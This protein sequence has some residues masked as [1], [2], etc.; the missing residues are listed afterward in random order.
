MFI[1]KKMITPFLLPPGIVIVILVA[2]GLLLLRKSWRAG[3]VNIVIGF[4]LWSASISPVSDALMRGLEADLAVPENPRGDVIILLGGGVYDSVPDLSGE[5]APSEDTLA[6]IVTAVR[7]QTM[8]RVPI[9]VCGGTV[10]PGRKAEAPV[11]ARI[12]K[13]LGVPAERIIIEDKSRDT[14]ENARYANEIC[15]KYHFER[16]L[17]VTSAYHTRRAVLSFKDVGMDVTAVPSGF[18]T[19]KRK[20]SWYDYLPAD[21][22]NSTIA[23]REYIGLLY[24]KIGSRIT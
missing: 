22:R 11:D 13:D 4:F 19:W 6:R 2:S 8:L 21:L 18:K 14:L 3:L 12:I 10:F 23:C 16:P 20:Y 9:I 24:H 5:G 1:F 17:L 15:N 7:L